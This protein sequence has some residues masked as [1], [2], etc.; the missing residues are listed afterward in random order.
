MVVLSTLLGLWLKPLTYITPYVFYFPAI[1]I[2]LWLA[3]FGAGFLA[4]VLT[5]VV[6]DYFFIA[7]YYTVYAH[8]RD[9]VRAWYFIVS[10]G[11]ICWLID[12]RQY[13]AETTI[14][15]QAEVLAIE[16]DKRRTLE[17]QFRQAQ[18]MEAVGRLAGG[19][20][21]DFNNLLT[22]IIGQAALLSWTDLPRDAQQRVVAINDAAER[23]ASLTSQLL[24]FSRKQ[25]LKLEPVDLNV[26][27]QQ[28]SG[29]LAR[30]L[31]EDIRTEIVLEPLLGF[32]KGDKN[33]LE[34]ILMNLA[35]NAR[36]AM[37]EGGK[38]LIETAKV[39]LD[40]NYVKTH[41]EVKPG[42]HAMLAISDTGVG[43]MEEHRARIFEPFF[44][45]KEQ[46]KGTGLGLAMVY[47]TV[48][49]MQGSI[50]V[51]T[52]LGQGTTFK[53]YFP[54]ISE[55]EVEAKPSLEANLLPGRLK[56]TVLVVEDNVLLRSLIRD[57]LEVEGCTV[58]TAGD[59]AEA[60][61][62]AA[63]FSG[64]IDVL[65]TDVVLPGKNGKQV[66][67]ELLRHRPEIKVAYTSGYTPDAIVNHGVLEEGVHFLQKPF[68][69]AELISVLRSAVADRKRSQ[70]AD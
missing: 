28:F 57:Y 29:V 52:E 16:E 50:W 19:V 70:G 67:E 3:G 1:L 26:I 15:R 2:A 30:L 56:L 69:R 11:F 27:V 63:E 21:H 10:F 49:Q 18:K 12:R 55:E 31:G 38:L 42:L 22:V 45:T 68:T 4:T 46:G 23:G 20:A 7:P 17:E 8:G 41:S 40:D 54:L 59:G 58:I 36:D 6:A 24:A 51:Y 62:L 48:K 13:R 14:E 64:R 32:V 65:L 44:T 47:G 61:N 39:E 34:Q 5:S 66:A 43:I 53:M 37:P 33:Q 35:V 25:M 60:G 9:L